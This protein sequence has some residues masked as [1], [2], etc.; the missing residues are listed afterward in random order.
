MIY[1]FA[2]NNQLVACLRVSRYIPENSCTPYSRI[3]S[4]GPNNV[5][6]RATGVD[7]PRFFTSRAHATTI[8]PYEVNDLDAYECGDLLDKLPSE[9]PRENRLFLGPI[10]DN[11]QVAE[12]SVSEIER[13]YWSEE[14]QRVVSTVNLIIRNL[15]EI[16]IQITKNPLGVYIP[17]GGTI[18]T[19]GVL[20]Q[21]SA[22]DSMGAW[23][24]PFPSPGHLGDSTC[25]AQGTATA[26]AWPQGSG[27]HASPFPSVVNLINSVIESDEDE[28]DRLKK[29][30]A[31]LEEDRRKRGLDKP[32]TPN[33]V[34][35]PAQR[36]IELPPEEKKP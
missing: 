27:H 17:P 22:R 20:S 34:G 30:L 15:S 5:Y 24:S 11:D 8:L 18:E 28:Y 3:E 35:L 13:C 29:R 26:F 2:K 31:D 7:S 1:H 6:V 19:E 14:Q 33:I 21:F 23:L 16:G 9:H 36:V 25:T 10:R 32:P 12:V 4:L